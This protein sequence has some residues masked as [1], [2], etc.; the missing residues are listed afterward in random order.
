MD[1]S[2]VEIK[3]P[4]KT[5]VSDFNVTVFCYNICAIL[6]VITVHAPVYVR[7][8]INNPKKAGILENIFIK[9]PIREIHKNSLCVLPVHR[10]IDEVKQVVPCSS[11]SFAVYLRHNFHCT[12][13]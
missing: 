3:R 12:H 11:T 4:Y 9:I 7:F 8:H 13:H 10:H 1:G 2:L 6:K 5:T